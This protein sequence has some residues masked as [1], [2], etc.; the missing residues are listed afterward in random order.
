[1]TIFKKTI[2]PVS[3]SSFMV[4]FSSQLN[5]VDKFTGM[6]ISKFPS[7]EASCDLTNSGMAS[8]MGLEQ[9]SQ[10]AYV[11]LVKK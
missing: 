11:F 7:K 6:F 2:F 1:M 4:H 5:E 10:I 9:S 8:G 3:T